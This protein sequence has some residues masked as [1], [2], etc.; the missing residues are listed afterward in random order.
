MLLLVLLM[1]HWCAVVCVVDGTYRGVLLLAL[2]LMSVL[3]L[4]LKLLLRIGASTK[5]TEL[6]VDDTSNELLY[7]M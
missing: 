6:C 2:L 1:V 4:I 3:V 5:Y 7:T